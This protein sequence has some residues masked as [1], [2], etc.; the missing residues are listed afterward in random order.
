[1]SRVI[2]EGPGDGHN[3]T[4]NPIK[5]ISYYVKSS[6]GVFKQAYNKNLSLDLY[7][8]SAYKDSNVFSVNALLKDGIG[9]F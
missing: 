2:S 4:P 1:V 6:A 7:D 3:G 5:T 8:N 9:Q